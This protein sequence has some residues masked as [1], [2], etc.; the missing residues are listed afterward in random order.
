M[1]EK[2]AALADLPLCWHFIGP[3]QSNKTALIAEVSDWVHSLDRLKVARRLSEQRPTEKGPLNVLIQVKTS[4]EDSKSG[5]L[6]EAVPELVAAIT[7]LPGLALRGLMT[8]PRTG[9]QPHPTARALSAAPR[10]DGSAVSRPASTG[11]P[12]NGHVS[13]PG[14]GGC[15]RRAYGT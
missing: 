2:A 4:D 7:E 11:H 8:I 5:V 9:Y 6:P 12:L 3:I 14:S 15:R 1:A 13:G 10:T